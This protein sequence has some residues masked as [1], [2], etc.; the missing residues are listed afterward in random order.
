MPSFSKTSLARL[1]SCDFRLQM[2]LH[3]AIKY[4]DI[5]VLEGHRGQR[6]QDEAYERGASKV[7]WPNGKHNKIPSMAVDI[8]PWTQEGKVDW[9]DI[10]A[11]ARMMGYVQRIGDEIGVKLRF[12]FDW[13]GDFR[14][15]GIDP[16]ETF[17]DAPHVEVVEE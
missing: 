5:V 11:A 10:A 7:K 9:K 16:N 1:A 6:E 8:W 14:T 3:I 13:D 15:A 2:I 4:I 17:L 12:G